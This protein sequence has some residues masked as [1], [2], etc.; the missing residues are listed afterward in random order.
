M[1]VH[2]DRKKQLDR[3][4]KT[5]FDCLIVGGGATGAGTAHD[6]SLRG[7][8][9]ALID[10]KDFSSGTSSRS[11]KLI[12]GGVRY[13]AQFHFGLIQEALTERKRLLANAPHLVKPLKFLMPSYKFYEKPYY[14]IGLTMYDLL[15]GDSGLPAHRRI[16]KHEF[17]KEFPAAKETELRGGIAYYDA[18][19]NDSR[20]NV[21][22][23]RTAEMEGACVCNKV[24][25]TSLI[26]N[27]SGKI[28]GAK[29]KDVTTDKEF[30]VATKL[31]INTTGVWI[32]EIRKM[33]DPNAK[34]VLS[35]S[36]GIHLVFPKSKIPCNSAM[37]IPKTSD[38]RVVFLLPWEDHVVMG[39]TD[40]PIQT[41]SHEPIPLKDEV[42]FLLKTGN[43]YL[44][45]PLKKEDIL[46]VFVGLR[47][48][49]SLSGSS[50]T[51]N[52]SREEMILVSDSNLITMS[53]GKWS[54]YRKMAEDLTDKMIQV[55]K[56]VPVR[57]CETY[58]YN[59]IGKSGYSENMYL[60][61]AQDYKL[62]LET[63]K[64]LRNYYGGEVFEILG[65]KPKEILKDSGFF[66][67]E[68][69]HAVRS[70]FALSVTDIIARR[71][72]ILFI[73]LNL[74]E[75]MIKPVATILAKE[76]KWTQTKKAKEEKEA[77]DLI[78]SLKETLN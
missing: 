54:T 13:L 18:Q 68:V 2:V 76:L 9:V 3:L 73:N 55:G 25:L 72:R 38:G 6:A 56:L 46:S 42:E 7:L 32:D 21:L 19:F 31:V 22:L 59:F 23:A 51:K 50:D 27:E 34:P 61:I 77:K 62:D 16:S 29:V 45:S 64:R 70:E 11:T 24:Q 37:I 67:E 47:P 69:L 4:S 48:L 39:T 52:I 66:E 63:A 41:I 8:N 35:P 58:N 40:T 53:G 17:L 57:A 12:H 71:M 43:E 5:Q 33:D 36:Q 20:L 15:A 75:S 60:K 44:S 1:A 28:V 30:T 26:K 10:A 49:I 74:A 65:K 78:Q 14:S